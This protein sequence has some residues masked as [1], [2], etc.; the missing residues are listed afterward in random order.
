MHEKIAIRRA[1]RWMHELRIADRRHTPTR[2]A[3]I[4]ATLATRGAGIGA[5]SRARRAERSEGVERRRL[6][7]SAREFTELHRARLIDCRR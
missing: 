7:D 1:L 2:R 6:V 5:E 3:R 4:A